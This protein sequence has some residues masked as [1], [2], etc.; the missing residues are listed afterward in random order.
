MPCAHHGRA[1]DRLRCCRG[2]IKLKENGKQLYYFPDQSQYTDCSPEAIAEARAEA[3]A[4]EDEFTKW[5]TKANELSRSKSELT[6]L[7]SVPMAH[8]LY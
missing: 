6:L 4:A 7:M 5:N 1:T 2:R 8:T 3:K